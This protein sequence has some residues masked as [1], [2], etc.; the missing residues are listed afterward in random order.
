MNFVYN[1]PI[2]ARNKDCL[3][4]ILSDEKTGVTATVK[5]LPQFVRVGAVRTRLARD[6][7]TIHDVVNRMDAHLDARL[8]GLLQR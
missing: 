8:A 2:R 5:S 3:I 1:L 4:A 7:K 6:S